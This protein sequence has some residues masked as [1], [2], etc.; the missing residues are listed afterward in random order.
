MVPIL[1]FRSKLWN[2]KLFLM[3]YYF[4]VELWVRTKMKEIKINVLGHN[5]IKRTSEVGNFSFVSWLK[6]CCCAWFL[7]ITR[8]ISEQSLQVIILIL[9][10][11]KTL[12]HYSYYP[13]YSGSKPGANCGI[14]NQFFWFLVLSC[15]LTLIMVTSVR[16]RSHMSWNSN[17]T[18][19]HII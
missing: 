5:L 7:P 17:S 18:P 3:F 16:S 15:T 19:M 14:V 13:N 2:V 11:I 6:F 1:E 4:I 12:H 8:C 9:V 10:I